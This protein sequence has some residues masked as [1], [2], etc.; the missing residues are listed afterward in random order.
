MARQRPDLRDRMF[1]FQAH[2]IGQPIAERR[3][4]RAADPDRP[5]VDAARPDQSTDGDE[6]AP[7]RDQQRDESKQFT[8]GQHKDHRRR[9]CRV[10]AHEGDDLIDV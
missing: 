9:P 6:H 10:I 3:T 8:E 7:G 1:E 4:E 2:P 5:E